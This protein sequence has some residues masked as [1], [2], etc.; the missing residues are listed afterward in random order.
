MLELFL[1]VWVMSDIT[2]VVDEN[3]IDNH[4]DDHVDEKIK[5]Y[6]KEKKNFF[7]FA[8]AG[9]GKT[10][11]LVNALKFIATKQGSSLMLKSK[12]VAVITYTKAAC[13]EIMR[14][15]GY[16]PLFA[17]STIH[18]FLWELIKPFQ[19]DIKIWVKGELEA[20]IDELLTKQNNP[21]RRKDYSDDIT[22]KQ[23][24]LA[25]LDKISKFTYN[26][27]GENVGQ[28]SLNHSEVISMGSAFISEE[29]TM[30]KVLVSKFPI[31]LI[32][33]SQDTKRELIDALLRI[34]NTCFDD[35]VIGMFGDT[36]QR[37][38]MDG[39][40]NLELAIPSDW[41][42]PN[43]VMNHRSNKRIIHLANAIRAVADGRK[44]QARSD[45]SEGFIKLFIVPNTS[46]KES[47]EEY[48]ST[49]MAEIT[50]DKKWKVA[51]E[52]KTLVLEHSM[53]AKRIGF[54]ILDS[55]LQKQ[56]SQSFRDGT[57]VELS[58]LMN[59]IYPIVL[60][61][62]DNNDFV[63]M[64]ILRANS[65][66]L[67]TENFIKYPDQKQ[68]LKDIK[69]D[70]CGL[71][72]LWEDNKIPTCID[73]YK[74]LSKMKLFDLPKRIEDIFDE[75][76]EASE[77]IKAL[78]EGL[79]I[80]FTELIAYWNYVNDNTQFSTH[81]GIKG[82]EYDRVTVII[83]DENA[84]GFLFSYE[85]LFGVT[86]ISETDKKN[87]SE[88]KDN[89]ISRTLRLLYVICTRA[90]ESLALIVYT[91]NVDVVKKTAIDYG[92]FA[93]EEIEFVNY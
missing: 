76:T 64:K 81:Q 1:E 31:L 17:V 77:A 87:A 69:N 15:V 91:G 10:R 21:R 6:I 35:F 73:V 53:A 92:W 79:N 20:N 52:R 43:K 46:D 27:N 50:L 62:Q 33:E 41:E 57:L 2:M 89:A 44:Q 18:S 8:G 84:G 68:V 22:K 34:D 32:D 5:T 55:T 9:S 83:D 12:Q 40:E 11:S 4:V 38:Y 58:F 49:K 72:S 90:K 59:V 85:K 19:K 75:N 48:V 37:I 14:R 23:K 26:P 16:N 36:M 60:A 45:K 80:P 74:S 24:R 30:Q 61:K 78:R 39:K 66:L 86:A 47:V 70:V 29:E 28:D 71:V 13:D 63:L 88:G 82:L 56:F 51:N 42:R 7:M 54:E 93:A 3:D 67:K 65:P 25:S